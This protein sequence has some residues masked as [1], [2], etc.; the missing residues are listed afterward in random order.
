MKN[1]IKELFQIALIFPKDYMIIF[2]VSKNTAYKMYYEDCERLGVNRIT[3][4]HLNQL[5]GY[6]LTD[7]AHA[8]RTSM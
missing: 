3:Q 4:Y 8:F 6:P 7:I 1:T 5:Y 2:E